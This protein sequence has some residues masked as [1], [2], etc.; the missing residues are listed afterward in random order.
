M[1]VVKFVEAWDSI[2]DLLDSKCCLVFVRLLLLHTSYLFLGFSFVKDTGFVR[3]R[4]IHQIDVSTT[5]YINRIQHTGGCFLRNMYT[6]SVSHRH[7]L[8][9]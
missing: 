8:H 7:I 3:L 9:K 1:N 4:C 5:N 6:T 2:L